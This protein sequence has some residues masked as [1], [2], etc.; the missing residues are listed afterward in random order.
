MYSKSF[1]AKTSQQ[2]HHKTP[3]H[4]ATNLNSLPNVLKVVLKNLLLLR[5]HCPRGVSSLTILHGEKKK[6]TAK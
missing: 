1:Y 2:W 4:K 6:T 5:H 3:V